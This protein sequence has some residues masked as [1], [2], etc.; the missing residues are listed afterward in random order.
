[1]LPTLNLPFSDFMPLDPENGAQ[2]LLPQD[3][4]EPEA[5]FSAV[6]KDRVDEG[7][8]ADGGEALPRD[9]K[10]LP[11][12]ATMPIQVRL[13]DT[14][15]AEDASPDAL[16]TGL[17]PDALSA[18]AVDPAA[19]LPVGPLPAPA[20]PAIEVE[21]TSLDAKRDPIVLT[22]PEPGIDELPQRIPELSPPERARETAPA[23]V[24]EAVNL[25]RDIPIATATVNVDGEMIQGRKFDPATLLAGRSE[26]AGRTAEPL[27]LPSTRPVRVAEPT[28]GAL[29][30][31]PVPDVATE[32][33][34][35]AAVRQ[36]LAQ[37]AQNQFASQLSNVQAVT[38]MQ[39]AVTAA[40]TPPTVT[41]ASQAPAPAMQLIDTPVFEP[42]WGER[43]GERVLLMA[44]KGI[45]SADIRLSPA[46]MG[47][48]RI[49]V[50]VDDGAAHVTFNAQHAATR[51]AIEQALPRLRELFTENGLSL[52]Q[53]NVGEQGVHQ[54]DRDGR[55]GSADGL[56]AGQADDDESPA[57]SSVTTTREARARGLI[58]TFA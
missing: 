17:S 7:F 37:T 39:A 1:M 40:A 49:Q 8:E 5:R 15:V 44:S 46:E 41:S 54:G 48:L 34:L 23:P 47:P 43:V 53:A 36:P 28:P 14:P 51:D 29:T 22:P 25:W 50:A 11:D 55:P 16:P 57:A 33:S 2:T 58:D 10:S 31:A 52:G 32:D 13:P 26:S 19:D 56:L 24:S 27:E 12:G 35:L 18:V 30:T 4:T 45:Q 42:A 38:G 21:L 3:A 6:L 9:G 20:P